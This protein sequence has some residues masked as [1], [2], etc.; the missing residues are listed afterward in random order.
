M[1]L[2]RELSSVSLFT[3]VSNADSKSTS[4]I[5]V[6]SQGVIIN[7]FNASLIVKKTAFKHCSILI[8]SKDVTKVFAEDA[9]PFSS[10]SLE[11]SAKILNQSFYN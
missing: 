3:N 4:T 11:Q 7:C 1:G 6:F 9:A 8:Q 2:I 5:L 10:I